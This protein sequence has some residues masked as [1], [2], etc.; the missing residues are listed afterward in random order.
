[1]RIETMNELLDRQLAVFIHAYFGAKP[2]R[3]RAAQHC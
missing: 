1:M 3:E 2:Y